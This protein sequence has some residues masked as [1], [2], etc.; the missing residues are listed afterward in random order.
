MDGYL[1]K[2]MNKQTY[3]VGLQKIDGF[4]MGQYEEIIIYIE[5]VV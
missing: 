1:H 5:H 2:Q 4:W 3:L